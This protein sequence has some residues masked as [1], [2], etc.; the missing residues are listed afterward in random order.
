M[1]CRQVSGLGTVRTALDPRSAPA[2][3]ATLVQTSSLVP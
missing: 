1:T 2:A 3:P